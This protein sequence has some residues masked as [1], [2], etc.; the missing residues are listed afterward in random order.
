MY[1][2]Y[3]SPSYNQSIASVLLVTEVV[4]YAIIGGG[5]NW[6]GALDIIP[7]SIAGRVN[8]DIHACDVIWSFPGQG[9]QVK[10]CAKIPTSISVIYSVLLTG[11]IFS[12]YRVVF[13]AMPIAA[14]W[15]CEERPGFQKH[16]DVTQRC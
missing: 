8:M 7:P 5:H 1:L 4:L 15:S 14:K 2:R 13:S 12:K 3:I 11:L 6:P 16:I 10:P 9:T